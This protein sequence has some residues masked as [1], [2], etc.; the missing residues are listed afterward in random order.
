MSELIKEE[1]IFCPVV[2]KPCIELECFAFKTAR[3]RSKE[4]FG[5]YM[6]ADIPVSRI[7]ENARWCE[8]FKKEIPLTYK[9]KH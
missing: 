6:A 2:K 4:E 3:T 7:V 8:L 9:I 1:N 5:D